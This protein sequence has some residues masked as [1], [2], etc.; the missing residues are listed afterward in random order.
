MEWSL[1]PSLRIGFR[2]NLARLSSSLRRAPRRPLFRSFCTNKA[3]QS[4]NRRSP[5]KLRL[6]SSSL[7]GA[8][9]PPAKKQK[10]EE[11]RKVC[12]QIDVI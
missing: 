10:M 7:E 6:M 4:S 8:L 3:T 5:V 11:T 1:L 9:D 12:R 2:P